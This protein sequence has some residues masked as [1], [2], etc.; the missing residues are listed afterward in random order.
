MHL[1]NLKKQFPIQK[2]R[3]SI[4]MK[5]EVILQVKVIGESEDRWDDEY[6]LNKALEQ[7]NSGKSTLEVEDYEIVRHFEAGS[8][9]NL[10]VK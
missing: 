4:K 7:Y 3:G 2:S 8:K 5:Y 6:L 1:T 10:D 9:D